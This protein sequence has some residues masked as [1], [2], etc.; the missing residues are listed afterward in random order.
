MK[1]YQLHGAKDVRLT[2]KPDPE[3]QS[4]QVVIRV[5]TMGICGSDLYYYKQGYCGRFVPKE[6]FAL[7]HEFSGI[8]SAT[9]SEVSGV[10]V[11]DRVTVDPSMPCGTCFQCRQGTYNRCTNMKFLGSAS[12]YPHIDGALSVFV[13]VPAENCFLLPDSVSLE[14]AALLEPLS[15]AVHAVLQADSVAGANVLITGGGT[16]GQLVLRVVQAFGAARTTVSDVTPF[17]RNFALE[18][19]ASDVIDPLADNPWEGH[20]G[21]DVVFEASGAVP[22]LDAA[23]Q[24]IARGGTLVQIGSLPEEVPISAN[25]IMTKELTVK[26]SFRYAH[27]FEK[28]LNLIASGSINLDGIIS[29]TYAYEDVPAAF[30]DALNKTEGVKIQVSV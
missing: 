20:D 10:E 19:G 13:V 14:Q 28:A 23:L 22:A 15:V 9:G 12:C 30:E 8:V 25:L 7:G 18:S 1:T 24:V 6:P 16:I 21:F 17:A 5:S 4:D 3:P 11:G 27:V 29:R 26:G 2:E